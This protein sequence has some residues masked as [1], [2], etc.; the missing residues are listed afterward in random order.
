M[1]AVFFPWDIHRPG[2]VSQPGVKV[3]KVVV[4]IKVS[5]LY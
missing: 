3:R 4:K 1:Y 2:C 5:D